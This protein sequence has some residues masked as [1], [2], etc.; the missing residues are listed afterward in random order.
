MPRAADATRAAGACRRS[1]RRASEREEPAVAVDELAVG[2]DLATRAQVADH[3]PV[4]RRAVRAA[5]LRIGRPEREVHRA[6]DLL[7]EEDVAGEDADR[8][9][10][11]ERELPDPPRA[12]VDR[13]HLLEEVLAARGGRLDHLA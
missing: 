1:R 3:V 7:V 9:V 11:A 10:Q 6:A 4:Q 13:D 2:V 8:L 5:A 12:L